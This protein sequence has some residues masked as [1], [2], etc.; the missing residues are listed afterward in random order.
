[1]ETK[2]CRECKRDL[3]L[4]KFSKHAGNKDGLQDRCKDCFSKYNR[5]R[6]ARDRDRFKKAVREYK[7]KNPEKVLAQRLSKCIAEPS[8]KRAYKVVEA[9]IASGELVRPD[10]CLGCGCSNKEHRI[11]A[12]HNSY[13]RPLEVLWLCTPCHRSMDARRRVREG[14]QPHG[15]MQKKG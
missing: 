11:E 5:E 4:E 1:M 14:K 6:Y 9:A 13:D 15:A 10:H 2:V 8:A 7:I 3:P 12:H